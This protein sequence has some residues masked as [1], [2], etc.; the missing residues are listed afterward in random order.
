MA[1]FLVMPAMAA[2]KVFETF[3]GDGFGI[4]QEE[5][6]AFGKGPVPGT[7]QGSKEAFTNY[8]QGSLAC[9]ANGG[10]ASTGSLTSGEFT[11]QQKY[12][13]FL[14]AGGNQPGKASVQL[15]ID[16]NVAKEAT[17]KNSYL[18]E[19][20]TWDMTEHKGK[21]ARLRV[22]DQATGDWGFI[23]ADHFLFTD[24]S[25]PKLPASTKDG[26]A[27]IMG[28]V[29]TPALPGV[30]IPAGTTLKV[31]ADAKNQQ[32]I[33]PTAL[34]FDEKGNIYVSETHRFRFGIEDN[35][36]HLYWYLDDL[37]A[38]TVEDRRKLH[39]KWQAKVSLQH[40]TEKSEIVRLL[41]DKDGDGVCE[42]SVVFADGF[43]DVLDGTAAGVFALE[44]TVYLASIPK[45]WA[46]RDKNG[47]GISD[48]K[49]VIQDGFGVRISLSGHDLNGFALGPDGMIHGTVGD[50][51]FSL[52]T[53]EGKTYRYP[54][55]GAYFRFEPDGSH[56]EI[57]H[58]GLRNPK[59]IAFD[60]HGNAI[61]VDNNSDQGDKARI[62]YLVP[63][64]DTGWQMEH[65]AMHTFAKQ[66]GLDA[67]PAS[68]WMSERMW[69][70]QNDDQPAFIVPA[71]AHLTSGPSGLT[72]HP[73]AGFLESEVGRFLICDY[74]GGASM[75]GIYS[76]AVAPAGAGMKLVDERQFNWGVAATDVEYSYDGKVVVAD[77]IG[78]WTSHGDGR[79]YSLDAG[80]NMHR[81][82]AVAQ[83]K[84]WFA[85][86][87]SQR[88]SADLAA[89]LSHPDMRVRLRAQIEL[90][91][92]PDG[93]TQFQTA[94]QSRSQI[95]RIHALW[96][97]GIIAR[98]G[99]TAAPTAD[100][101][102]PLPDAT[103]MTQATDMLVARLQDP[104]AEIRTQ[105]LR[106]LADAKNLNVQ[107]LPLMALLKDESKR[108]VFHA[109]ILA[110][111]KKAAFLA[112]QIIEM[113]K[114]N[115][116]KDPFLR[117]AGSYAMA[118]MF[119]E[120]Y[121]N[122][123]RGESDPCVRLAA[124][125]AL[126]RLKSPV[127][128]EFVFDENQRVA[129]EAVRAIH[130]LF[131]ESA[132]PAV[133]DLLDNT[134]SVTRPEMIWRRILHSAFRIGGTKNAQRLLHA[135]SAQNLP[136]KVRQEAIRLL[137]QWPRPFPVDQSIG[138][139]APLPERSADEVKPLLAQGMPALIRA[140]GDTLASAL[141]LVETYQLSLDSVSPADLAAIVDNAQ[142]SGNARAKA[143]ALFLKAP[144]PEMDAALTRWSADVDTI[145]ALSALEAIMARQ[146][147]AALP[148]LQKALQKNQPAL[149]QGAWT[150]LAKVPG[151]AAADLIAAGVKELTAAKGALPF[152]I[153]ILETAEA[154][155][156]EKVKQALSAWEASLDPADPLASWLVALEGG[157]A[158]RGEKIYLSHPAECMRCH[159][160]GDGH[161][162]G[163]EVGPNLAGIGKRGDHHFLLESIM[164]PAAKVA[165]GY[166]VVSVTLRD[167]KSLGGIMTAEG[168]DS[169]DIDVGETISRVKRSDIKE[170]TPPLSAMPPMTGLLKPREARDLVAWL[171]T[172]QK[173]AKG[174]KSEKKVVPVLISQQSPPASEK[175]TATVAAPPAP[176]AMPVS[177]PAEK[178]TAA[179]EAEISPEVMA[180]GKTQYTACLACHGADGNGAT[181]T[182][183]P[184]ARSEWVLGP[185]ENLIRIQL[186][187]LQGP[188][189]V[190][191]VEYNLAM[192]AQAHQTD[193]QIAAV[194]T[195]IR[196]NFGNKASAVTPEE[197]AA[198]RSEVGKPMIT[199]AELTPLPPPP[200]AEATT[201][202][203][204]RETPSAI[205]LSFSERIG[206]PLWG[207]ALFGLWVALCLGVALKP[208]NE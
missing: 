32:V 93:L 58:T 124:V 115:Q 193:D 26:K 46:L 53:K 51:G 80:A 183:P 181:G 27:S 62:V 158:E 89:M 107:K 84:Q 111:K 25:N 198:L 110:A 122:A 81:P 75:S 69:E 153:E 127:L 143:L 134:E 60:M 63:G 41:R 165:P 170:M 6:T 204:A 205:A 48:E 140:G 179:A 191:G 154:R 29:A 130:D 8:A 95:E 43:N 131:L 11:V 65:Q 17:G 178:P 103:K 120:P 86:G 157:D 159:R 116:D 135:A 70:T 166:G 118:E 77:F 200:A 155:S 189:T 82:D 44:G 185:V 35:R 61:S 184:L 23:A 109:A 172:L 108:V 71:M 148:S 136:V 190:K 149:S 30:T 203:M 76:F 45:I 50:R 90:T 56:F 104:D 68:R 133:A 21:T 117:H 67:H 152:A 16:G 207:I 114:E 34:C 119:P 4:W 57:I 52:T 173:D 49:K 2:D 177:T 59:E 1:A 188:I 180:L 186:R 72:Y 9:S 139:W 3:E 144:S 100:G 73:G 47:D 201:E 187:G 97:T 208:R 85:E 182:G 192:P 19:V 98:R 24:D 36:N 40:M 38:K 169:I 168:K 88:S 83:V 146:P 199:V 176:A 31:I 78:G 94:L 147:A 194:L 42:T 160:A 12:V 162:A 87:F 28:L 206:L 167:G 156:E 5:G 7:P 39:V 54:N 13:A 96:G 18:C 171:A 163:G 55:E 112:P 142:L 197:V 195:Y 196:N 141:G 20:V 121:F 79:I 10:F 151:S 175:P 101:F 15:L 37:A 22:L 33:S 91:R 150:L 164:V 202:S 132:R 106:M 174:K 66:I 125:V 14:I 92:R 74:R 138:Y 161:E 113:L 126:R 145:L 123:L 105:A 137:A 99:I 128:R 129:E 102:A 64:G